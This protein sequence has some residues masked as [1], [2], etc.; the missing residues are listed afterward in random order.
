VS[1]FTISVLQL[2]ELDL[3]ARQQ[4][5]LTSMTNELQETRMRMR[6]IVESEA[7]SATGTSTPVD[8]T[9]SVAENSVN[10]T[11]V[12]E[13]TDRTQASVLVTKQEADFTPTAPNSP[14]LFFK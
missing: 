9:I 13:G 2:A 1:I 14:G 3:V 8:H 4:Q 11:E 5:Q 7:Q 10:E 12:K 6:S